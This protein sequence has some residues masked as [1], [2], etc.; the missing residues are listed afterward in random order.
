MYFT[1]IPL[2]ID[3]GVP[4][5]GVTF[6]FQSKRKIETT[7]TNINETAYQNA[8]VIAS[9]TY[10]EEE[11]SKLYNS[12]GSSTLY[13]KIQLLCSMESEVL[14]E[15]VY[16]YTCLPVE[17][18]KISH[19]KDNAFV[20]ERFAVK[21]K[22][23]SK[24]SLDEIKD[25]FCFI[26][27][28]TP[29]YNMDLRH[30]VILAETLE[31]ILNSIALAIFTTP[32]DLYVFQQTTSEKQRFKEI[33]DTLF[34]NS[35]IMPVSFETYQKPQAEP[36]YNEKDIFSVFIKE[37]SKQMEMSSSPNPEESNSEYEDSLMPLKVKEKYYKE[38]KRLKR[39]PQSSLEYQTQYDYIELL[40]EIPWGKYSRSNVN[41]NTIK[42]QLNKT[43][44]GLENIKNDIVY[45]FALEK[46]LKKPS[47]NVLCFLGPPGTGKTSIVKSIAEA[48]GK[49]IVKI[50]LGGM[51]DE[52]EF[53]GHRR[54]YVSSKPGRIVTSLKE[55]QTLNPIILLDEI[56]KITTSDRSNPLAALLEIL[57]PE[58]NDSFIDRYL[59]LPL[60]LSKCVFIATANY[61]KNI[62]PPLLDRLDIIEFKEYTPEEKIKIFREYTL[63]KL[64]EDLK[65]THF[66]I[67][68]S[69]NFSNAIKHFSTRKIEK[70]V[71]KIF[72]KFIYE[73][74]TQETTQFTLTEGLINEPSSP[75]IGFKN[76][77]NDKKN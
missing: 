48:T 4:L 57:D 22:Y 26:L 30:N 25:L 10:S 72:K 36:S 54:T 44:K 21:D 59:E 1:T 18:M 41:L 52:A 8:F 49:P 24:Y 35:G 3:L 45:H 12:S 51:N 32:I 55:C 76:A 53:R 2:S 7:E 11:I 69:E 43:H 16:T 68:E 65:I 63:P 14:E 60:D 73:Y 23:P 62:P 28:N 6:T 17:Y 33:L 38:K 74:L 77:N 71:L 70:I 56:D 75:K 67:T 19:K 40:E 46:H 66:E 61:K 15:G 47:G 37:V 29:V 34:E 42:E 58:Q 39:L 27:E 9:S 50:A 31:E 13:P 64:K 5:R 20:F